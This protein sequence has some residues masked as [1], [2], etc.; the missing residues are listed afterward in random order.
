MELATLLAERLYAVVPQAEQYDIVIWMFWTLFVG[1]VH[2]LK[3]VNN[4][5]IFPLKTQNNELQKMVS[6]GIEPLTFSLL[7]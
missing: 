5:N 3:V 7:D 1:G 6:K 2:F 4:K